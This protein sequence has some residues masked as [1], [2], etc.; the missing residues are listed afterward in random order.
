MQRG[1]DKKGQGEGEK[2]KIEKSR[3]IKRG[4]KKGTLFGEEGKKGQRENVGE[5]L[6]PFQECCCCGSGHIVAEEEEVQ[7]IVHLLL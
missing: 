4:I 2:K 6:V 5:N 7:A 3:T 1:K